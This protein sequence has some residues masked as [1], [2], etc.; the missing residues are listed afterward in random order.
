[1]SPTGVVVECDI[2][3]A[4]SDNAEEESQ[5]SRMLLSVLARRYAQGRRA[6]PG[7]ETARYTQASKI[8]RKNLEEADIPDKPRD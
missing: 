2:G 8:M 3:E 1:L 7:A 4:V 6:D 5:M